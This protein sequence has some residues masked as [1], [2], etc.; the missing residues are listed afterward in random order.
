MAPQLAWLGLGGMGQICNTM[1]TGSIFSFFRREC[2]NISSRKA[3]FSTIRSSVI[4]LPREQGHFSDAF[5]RSKVTESITEAASKADIFY[6]LGD[7][8]TVL[9]IVEEIL[10]NDIKDKL[11]RDRRTFVIGI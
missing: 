7:D 3:I 2:S 6:C 11:T 1:C 8:A 9:S 10:K 4:A 5:G